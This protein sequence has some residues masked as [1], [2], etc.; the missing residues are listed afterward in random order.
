[1]TS[2]LVSW[3]KKMHSAIPT[4]MGDLGVYEYSLWSC[5]NLQRP[6]VHRFTLKILKT[7]QSGLESAWL[8]IV[9]L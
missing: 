1:M 2:V 3:D 9:L 5:E 7:K 4:Q 8:A 6:S